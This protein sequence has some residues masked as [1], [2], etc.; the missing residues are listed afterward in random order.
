MDGSRYTSLAPYIRILRGLHWGEGRGE[1]SESSCLGV[2]WGLPVRLLRTKT[3]CQGLVLTYHNV[4]PSIIMGSHS[5]TPG[6]L[7]G[8]QMNYVFVLASPLPFLPSAK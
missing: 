5:M 1:R 8:Y 2:A 6:S 4:V 7:A 3:V